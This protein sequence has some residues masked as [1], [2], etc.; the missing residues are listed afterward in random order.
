VRTA[1]S[2]ARTVSVIALLAAVACARA[3]EDDEAIA[4]LAQ[5]LTLHASFD[6][7][8]DADFALGDATLYT[9]PSYQEQDAAAAGIGSPEIEIVEGSGRFGDALE[10]KQKNTF[11][12]FYRAADNVAFS[13]SNWSGTVSFWLSLEPGQDLEPG[14]CDPIQ[15]TDVAYN[16]AAIWV[17][18]TNENPRQFRLGIFGD[19]AVWNPDNL[20]SS[21]YPFFL[22]RLIAVDQPPFTRGEWTH[23]TI[24][25]SGLGSED[26]G[27]ANL[28]LNGE[29]QSKTMAGI[30]E[31]FT[32][33]MSR[34]AIRLGV[35]YVGLYD[36]LAL[37][38]RPLTA[39]EV[40]TLRGL[41]GGVALLHR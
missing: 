17:D 11:A 12:V 1:H 3:A 16:D 28:Y 6:N 35:N 8:P 29:P 31:P 32:W 34:A 19:L 37:F 33:D 21:D 24:T 7:G 5:A 39:E 23:V 2:L 20:S 22:E 10:F 41:E 27:S 18:F 15:I 4:S 38:N 13:A 30:G 40:A 26:G 25:F 9:A 36:E 14:F